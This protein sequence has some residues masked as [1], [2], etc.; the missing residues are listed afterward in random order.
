[1]PEIDGVF[2]QAESEVSAIN[3]VYGSAGC[4]K[5]VMTSSSSPGVS[6]KQEGISYL[7]GSE[8]PA[9]IVNVVRAG[10]GLG[11]IAPEQSDYF[12]STRGGGHGNYRHVVLAPNSVQEMVDHT[13]LAFELAD[14]Y[15]NP[16]ILQGDGYLGQMMEPV[17]FPDNIEPNPD[18][19]NSWATTGAEGREP[20]AITSIHIAPEDLENHNLKLEAKYQ[21]ITADETRYEE[22]LCDDADYIA[23]AFGITSR[24]V[25]G[26][27]E[28]ARSQGLKVGL[29]RP[30]TLWPF[31]TKRLFELADKCKSL[32]VVELNT[33]QM[34]DDVKIAV[35]G[36]KEIH[37]FGRCGGIVPSQEEVFEQMKALFTK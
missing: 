7:A 31:P 28:I 3:M 24:I 36:K 35:N 6:L 20:H 12:Q 33:G 34:I 10:P 29:L 22:Y 30:I 11:S 13:I 5:R 9:V 37:W 18:R 4:G 2:L 21:T 17:E 16:V 32:M 23:V 25:K 19:H 1:M 15:R 14:K 8:L 26:A 27:I